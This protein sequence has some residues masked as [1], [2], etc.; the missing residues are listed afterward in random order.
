MM[1]RYELI[2]P[3]GKGGMAEVFLA[4]RRG[5]GGVEKRLVVKRVRRE[6]ARDARF[7]DLF[8]SEARLSMSLAHR[9]IVSVF[10]FGRAGDELFLVMEHV[11][12]SDLGAAL[13]A[14]RTAGG[15]LDPQI[16]AFIAMEACEALD[17]AQRARGE[18]G[19]VR[20]IVH[21]DITPG[22]VLLSRSGEVK[23]TDFGIALRETD[24]A[25]T[26]LHGTPAYMSP[27]QARGEALDVR[28]DLF[29][30]GLVLFEALTGERAYPATGAREVLELARR[31]EIPPLP[32]SVPA[33]LA[34]IVRRATRPRAEDRY[35]TPREMQLALDRY[36]VVVRSEA[37]GQPPTVALADWLRQ[38]IPEAGESAAADQ[39][40]TP[41]GEVRTFLDDGADALVSAAVTR[42][43]TLGEMVAESA[44]RAAK[45][46]RRWLG[47][48]VGGSALALLV[49]LVAAIGASRDR[50]SA[51]VAAE[52]DVAVDAALLP[53]PVADARPLAALA[54]V[55]PVA[56]AGPM[57]AVVAAEIAD[58]GHARA[59]VPARSDSGQ[60]HR[61]TSAPVANPAASGTIK[62]SS[63]PWAEVSVAGASAR[64]ADTPCTLSL[65]A[66][67]Y[68]LHL[69]NPVLRVAK[70][71][72]VEVVAGDTRYV[73]EVLTARE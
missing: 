2:A 69:S 15:S 16:C 42:A 59:S 68:T 14:A 45:D 73:K 8:V 40:S 56:D 30:V 63:Q 50:D 9:N 29:S 55:A 71:V 3:L 67:T 54:A 72:R 25:G 58:A 23:V 41:E 48:A 62:V 13:R 24:R 1:G 34:E 64:C 21:R 28:S 70:D 38:I 60:A 46:G 31:G 22:N 19:A 36:L 39:P 32:E 66:G 4:R 49:G 65:P 61:R 12:G 47:W 7:L 51:P 6:R 57:A 18:G 33:S 10:D 27:E 26:G 44:D 52:P 43:E 35:Q 11:D 20:A 5:P 37:A 53:A 17:Y